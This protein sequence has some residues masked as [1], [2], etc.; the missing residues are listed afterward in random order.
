MR[1]KLKK[2]IYFC[3]LEENIE[4]NVYSSRTNNRIQSTEY[5]I[6]LVSCY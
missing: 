5:K 4:I 1:K 6:K 3:H 2:K